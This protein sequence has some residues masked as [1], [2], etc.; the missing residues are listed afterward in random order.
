MDTPLILC[1][2]IDEIAWIKINRPD[3]L[4]ALNQA[5]I[6]ELHQQLKRCKEDETVRVVILTGSG[7]KAFV[8]G[9]DVTEFVHLDTSA[10]QKLAVDGEERIF[11]F[12]EHFNK[13]VLAAINGY[14]L[15]GGVELALSCHLRIAS[16]T[17]RFGFPEVSLGIIP[18]Y[19]ATQRLP[20]LIGK[21]RALEL[22]L[23]TKLVNAPTAHQWGLVNE[24]VPQQE[25]LEKAAAWAS[26]LIKQSPSAMAR[27]ITSV[28]AAFAEEEK[29]FRMEKKQFASCFETDDFKEGVAAFLEKR[30]PR[31]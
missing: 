15:G 6:N 9:A 28:N 22:I 14:A 19:G 23:T 17:A 27:A 24:I 16:D 4:N 20:K 11:S 3:K 26:Q 21:G 18:G 2:I 10:A 5:L 12:I 7:D 8:A 13:P 29:G 1:E 30:K 31:F 25:L